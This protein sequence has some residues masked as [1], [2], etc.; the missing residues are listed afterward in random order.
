MSDMDSLEKRI[1]R[2]TGQLKGIER[3]MR[4][5]RPCRETLQQISAVKKAIDSLTLELIAKEIDQHVPDKE[6]REIN[7][8]IEQAIRL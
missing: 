5:G 3:M 4:D 1:N 2:M 6:A 7:R 8:V